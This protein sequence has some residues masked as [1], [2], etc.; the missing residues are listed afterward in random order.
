M[1]GSRKSQILRGTM[2]ISFKKLACMTNILLIRS[3][4]GSARKMMELGRRG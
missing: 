4:S 2:R 3:N 1:W